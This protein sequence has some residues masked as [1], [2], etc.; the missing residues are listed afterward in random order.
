MYGTLREKHEKFRYWPYKSH[1]ATIENPTNHISS[2]RDI[3]FRSVENDR[4]IIR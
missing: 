4:G 2:R 3:V 1:D